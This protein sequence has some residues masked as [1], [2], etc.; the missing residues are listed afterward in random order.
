M[1]WSWVAASTWICAAAERAVSASPTA[2]SAAR[3]RASVRM[4]GPDVGLE[5]RRRAQ[6][7]EAHPL[8]GGVV[9]LV[10]G[11]VRGPAG[12]GV[13]FRIAH[14]L[15]EP[16]VELGRDVAAGNQRRALQA[17]LTHLDHVEPD[18]LLRIILELR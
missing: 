4:A 5:L 1:L 18:R 10:L 16:E 6:Q 2:R 7:L 9:E 15:A 8:I 14:R 17:I 12:L 3:R 11:V 13:G